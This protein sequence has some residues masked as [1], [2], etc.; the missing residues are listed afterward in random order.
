MDA[1]A[2]RPDMWP[3]T[4]E[5]TDEE[6]CPTDMVYP[7]GSPAFLYSAANSN[8]VLR[9]FQWMAEYGVDGV[10]LQRF[11]SQLI[12]P[13]TLE[14]RNQLSGYVHSAADSYG[15]VWAIMYDVTGLDERPV[16]LVETFQEDWRYL[17]DVAR[18][19]ESPAYLHHEGLPVVAIW[20]LGYDD[21]PGTPQ[22]AME[23]VAFFQDNSDPRYRA[24]VMGGV[25]FSWRV[26]EPPAEPDLAWAD[27]Y[28]SLDII[29]PWTVGAYGVPG[30]VDFWQP[31]MVQDM[32]RAAECGAE[33][34]PVVYPG[35]SY[36]NPD[37]SRPFNEY[38]R[39]GGR[40]Y[41]HQ[42]FRALEAGATMVYNAMFDEV[43]EGTA[44]YK[45]AATAADAPAGLELVTLDT[46]GDCLPSD[47]Y[48]SLAGE[49]SRMVRG[50]I[51]LTDTIP[52]TAQVA[53]GCESAVR[54]RLHIAT[55]SDWTTVAI[56]RAQMVDVRVV[57]ASAE[58]EQSAFDSGLGQLVLTQSLD[59]A[60]GGGSVEMVVELALA[61]FDGPAFGVT[62]GRGNLGAT[63]VGVFA[64]AGG[65]WIDVDSLEWSGVVDGHNV[66]TFD[67]A[68]EAFA[69]S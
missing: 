30:D 39:Q 33:Y 44:M 55:T 9:H 51:A 66:A 50:E 63:T 4:T 31:A 5:L 28:C 48:L 61:G 40:L 57:S 60:A 27:Y 11:G 23:L 7:D 6:R 25:P 43:D 37:P 24:T 52:I 1:A 2:Y 26:P 17:V 32:A 53:D 21:R 47:W 45:V 56:G 18:V 34:M 13:D 69:A 10:F 68:V 15:R 3:D 20:G 58:A 65:D 14:Q 36:H 22:Q 62:I 12:Y 8:T 41:W 29:S 54:A 67:V 42:V 46:D 38:P 64:A 35:H 16:D 49:A 59:R 19:T